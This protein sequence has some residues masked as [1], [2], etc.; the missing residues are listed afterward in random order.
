MVCCC[1]PR[2][3]GGVSATLYVVRFQKVYSPHP[4]G[5]FLDGLVAEER[6]A[7]FPASAGVFPTRASDFRTIR[8]IPR[9]RG[10][11]SLPIVKNTIT[12]VYSP[13]PR[14]CFPAVMVGRDDP[15]VFPASAGVFPDA[16]SGQNRITGI[17]RIRG[18]VSGL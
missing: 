1:I 6:G 5:C 16:G 15:G 4:R 2:I 11:V 18:G 9:I 10:G 8:G 3:R 12:L 14:G 13:H 7:V 17:P